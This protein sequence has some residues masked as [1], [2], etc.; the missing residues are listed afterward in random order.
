MRRKRRPA[1]RTEKKQQLASFYAKLSALQKYAQK[2]GSAN[3]LDDIVNHTLDAIQYTLGFDYTDFVIAKESSL[4]IAGFRG[5]EPG[6]SE[7]DFDGKGVT[8]RVFKTGK[9][10]ML[11]NTRHEPDYVDFKRK[12]KETAMLSELVVPVIVDEKVVAELDVERQ[13]LNAFTKED[14]KLLEIL[15]LQVAFAMKRLADLGRLRQS[16]E[17]LLKS[18]RL[19]AIG[20]TAAMVAHDIRN[21]LQSIAGASYLLKARTSN[22]DWKLDEI[23]RIIDK[24][25]EYSDKLLEELMEYS[26]DITLHRT[27]SSPSFLIKESISKLHIPNTI[28]VEDMTTTTPTCFVDKD[29]LIRVFINIIENAL[30]AMS[31]GGTLTISN[32]Q[33]NGKMEIAFA[34]TGRGISKDATE[35]IWAPL[36]T[37][38][39]KG[40][41]L[42]LAI[43]KRIAEAH[44]GTINVESSLGKGSIFTITI[45]STAQSQDS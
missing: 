13:T 38:K 23:I 3:S 33:V 40:V 5:P 41:G 17:Q 27:E 8:V 30:D 19:A 43:C 28:R 44:G 20:E 16:Q 2:L 34:D 4:R 10:I 25:V 26:R 24:S 1:P 35:K 42:G 45:P 7:L 29:Q 18:Q 22:T 6:I 36:Y 15:A 32:K 39:P 12:G 11:R 37:T 31:T 9:T 21:P 14:Q